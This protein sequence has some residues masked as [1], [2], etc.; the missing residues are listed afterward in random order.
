[1]SLD[2]AAFLIARGNRRGSRAVTE[3][4][5]SPLPLGNLKERVEVPGQEGE[6]RMDNDRIHLPVKDISPKGRK[7]KKAGLAQY[8]SDFPC[9]SGEDSREELPGATEETI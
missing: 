4:I 9:G 3:S 5:G 2:S 8:A 7:Y 1:M 6:I